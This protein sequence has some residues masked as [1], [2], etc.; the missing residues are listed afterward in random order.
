M[1]Y[2]I[3]ERGKMS[4]I[5]SKR[6]D[7]GHEILKYAG[8]LMSFQE[9]CNIAGFNKTVDG[10]HLLIAEPPL[11][12]TYI[13]FENEKISLEI[14]QKGDVV[15]GNDGLGPEIYTQIIL[16]GANIE[17]LKR[18]IMK[19]HEFA[20]PKTDSRRIVCRRF[21]NGT[22]WCTYAKKKKKNLDSVFLPNNDV[23]NIV[24]DVKK[25]LASEDEYESYGMPNKRVY[26]LTGTPGQGKSILAF[27]LACHFN[28]DLYVYSF[29]D[30]ASDSSLIR[31]VHDMEKGI[32]LLEDVDTGLEQGKITLNAITNIT[33][34]SLV[35]DR[36]I[37]F[38]TTNYYEKLGPVLTRPGRI[39]YIMKFDNPKEDVILRILKF[40]RKEEEDL[41][42][43]IAT[44]FYSRNLSAAAII[45]LLFSCR[46][47]HENLLSIIKKKKIEVDG[48]KDEFSYFS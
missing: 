8:H 2:R 21:I 43:K 19:A 23:E 45:S 22:Y 12:K 28:F 9:P 39:D 4:L 27:A 44:Y 18:F 48:L 5:L 10:E 30:H 3:K 14:I 40:Y 15:S 47:T 16:S 37:V 13:M 11:G 17:M 24:A 34:G 33:D 36:M 42:K 35:K 6:S 41:L 32:L 26:L 38:M 31:A 20:D 7:A 1:S 46:D 29:C 25:F